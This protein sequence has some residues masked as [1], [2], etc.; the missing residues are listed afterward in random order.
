[1]GEQTKEPVSNRERLGSLLVVA[2]AGR[3][4]AESGRAL[5]VPAS[6]VSLL[7]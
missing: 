6:V 1:V 3:E 4:L 5:G 7:E 2:I